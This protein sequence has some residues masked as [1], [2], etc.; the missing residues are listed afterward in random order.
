[1]WRIDGPRVIARLARVTGDVGAA[2]DHA[3]DALVAAIERWP[4]DGVPANPGA[5]LMTAA[6]NRA[7]DARRHRQAGERVAEALGRDAREEQ[8][9]PPD[10]A[11]AVDDPVGDEV[12]GLVVALCHPVLSA[13]ARVA[14]TLRLL[15]GLSTAEIARA[16]LTAESTVAQRITRAKRTLA[17]ARVEIAVPPKADLRP[18]LASVLEVVYLIFNEGYSAG[19]GD[20]WVRPALCEDAM[21]LGRMLARL[22]PADGEVH[23]LVALMELQASRL[24]ARVDRR[25][26]R[27]SWPTRTAAAGI[28]SSSAAGS[29]RSNGRR[30]A[31]PSAHTPSRRR[32]PPATRGPPGRRTPTGHASRRSTTPWR[33]WSPRR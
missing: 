32:S 21:R 10:L 30:T 31:A 4:V 20:D 7:I 26:T 2:E 33:K 17:A 24:G 15:G 27:C 13:E 11:A 9:T 23:G 22:M 12:L 29:R 19:S 14:L 3:Q 8:M 28:I 16:Y 6:T 25:G 1:V 5:W 18:R